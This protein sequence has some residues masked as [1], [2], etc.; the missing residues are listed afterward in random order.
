MQQ[1]RILCVAQDEARLAVVQE[2]AESAQQVRPAQPQETRDQ[3]GDRGAKGV[4]HRG[5]GCEREVGP[6][7]RLWGWWARARGKTPGR[8]PCGFPFVYRVVGR[9]SLRPCP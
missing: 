5:S 9:R 1:C 2:L 8:P 4:E 3:F 6:G 7:S